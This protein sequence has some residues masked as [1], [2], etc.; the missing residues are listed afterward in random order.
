ME[1]NRQ[2]ASRP[3]EV[4]R[5]QSQT[6]SESEESSVARQHSP[7]ASYA[8]RIEAAL[9]RRLANGRESQRRFRERQKVFEF[10]DWQ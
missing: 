7:T 1:R 4:S 2:S 9:E 10:D 5:E 8:A 3:E 6:R